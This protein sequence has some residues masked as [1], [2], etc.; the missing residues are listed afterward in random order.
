MHNY[1]ICKIVAI[2]DQTIVSKLLVTQLHYMIK[3]R[4]QSYT[5]EVKTYPDIHT[6]SSCYKF[7]D[8]YSVVMYRNFLKYSFLYFW[9]KKHS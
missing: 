8:Y 6:Q 1:K 3:Y 5:R 4:M 7:W 2:I 9:L